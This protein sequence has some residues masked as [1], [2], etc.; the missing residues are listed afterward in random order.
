MILCNRIELS[1]RIDPTKVENARNSWFFTI[2][3]L[4]M[5]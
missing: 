2:D 3:I 1:Q 4:S 5:G